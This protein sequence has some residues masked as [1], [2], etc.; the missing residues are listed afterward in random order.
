M[1][2]AHSIFIFHNALHLHLN[3]T[4]RRNQGHGDIPDEADSGHIEHW[5]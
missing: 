1:V 2:L 5:S 4:Q 3:V